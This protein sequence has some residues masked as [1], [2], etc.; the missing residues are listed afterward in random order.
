M[1]GPLGFL[2]RSPVRRDAFLLLA[3]QT[4]YKL[5]GIVLL[6]V[7][8][9]HLAAGE[10]GV[11][12]F[13]LS[14]AES[15]LVL[16]S[17]QLN[18]VMMR[19]VA[20]DM[21]QASAHLA[22]LLGFRLFGG[23]VYLLCVSVVAVALAEGIWR[24]IMVV[25]LFTLLENVYS[26][27]A[28]FFIALGKAVYN[29]GIGLAAEIF[30]M[31]IF[32]LGM[33]WA[34]SLNVLLEANLLRSLCLLG[35]AF[36]VTR[37]RLCPVQIS[38]DARFVRDGVPFILT[39]LIALL[40]DRVDTLLLGFFWDYKTIGHYHL[41]L[42]V[43][44]ASL[45]IPSVV[46]QVL[47]PRLSAHGLKADNRRA[48]VRGVAFLLSLGLLGMGVGFLFVFPLT[49]ILYSTLS[50][51]V[52]PLLRPLT[53]LI[54]L[55]FLNIFLSSTLQALYQETKALRALAI[56]TGASILT[57]CAL[58]PLIGVYGA[59]WTK[60]LSALIQLGILIWYLRPLFDQ[61]EPPAAG[62]YEAKELI[63]PAASQ[64]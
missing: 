57:N 14:F 29:F 59:V 5:S 26:S 63:P 39:S 32:L 36:F 56:G 54:P 27:F 18:P 9:R 52:A 16:A 55:S 28:T 41:A 21:A 50:T 31:S 40:G 47:F 33:W 62:R 24:V 53:L 42:K 46:G 19:R 25:A 4:F 1:M 37:Q 22:P 51:E 38:W 10:I 64:W 60:L 61:A 13:A 11:Y 20:A 12:F 8:S 7:L 43:V 48:F 15:F 58:I 6:M 35:A 2:R 49:E 44:V 34:P 17:F 23:P 3:L 45:F 30:F